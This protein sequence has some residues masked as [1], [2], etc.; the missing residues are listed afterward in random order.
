MKNYYIIEKDTNFLNNTKSTE[1]FNETAIKV[2]ETPI[3][4]EKNV[5]PQILDSHMAPKGKW[6]KIVV[7]E[8]TLQYQWNDHETIYYIDSE[9]SLIIEPERLHR[10]ILCGPVQFKV[11]FY[12]LNNETLKEFT[13]D[14][15]RPGESFL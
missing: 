14:V 13:A 7:L 9:N 11:E 15:L 1:T 4:S 3:M 5:F 6:G 12:K 10:V 8:G 2:G